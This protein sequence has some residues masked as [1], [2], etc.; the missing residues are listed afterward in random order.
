MD[1]SSV[2]SKSDVSGKGETI[3]GVLIKIWNLSKEAN[4][5]DLVFE[6]SRMRGD[7]YIEEKEF[8]K[9]LKVYKFL[10]TYC[11]VADDLE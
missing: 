11:K 2:T 1:A 4:I 8:I 7:Y 9:A 3:D 10:R 6:S 5:F